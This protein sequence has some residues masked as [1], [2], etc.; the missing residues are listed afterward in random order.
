MAALAGNWQQYKTEQMDEYLKKIG[1]G[2]IKRT[3]V[4]KASPK[5]T[6]TVDGDKWLIVTTTFFTTQTL[7]FTV[8]VEFETDMPAVADGKFKCVATVEGD[9][10]SVTAKPDNPELKE[11]E[12]IREIV[13]D[14]LLMTMKC[15]DVVCKRY[16]KKC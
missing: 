5:M 3:M 7:D 4:C 11:S 10:I 8:G 9:K 12:T 2:M 6:I 1:L 14:E 15:D 13:G 16:F